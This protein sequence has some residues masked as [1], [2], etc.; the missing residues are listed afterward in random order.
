MEINSGDLDFFVK[1]FPILSRYPNKSK[2]YQ[3]PKLQTK[4]EH[5]KNEAFFPLCF[6]RVD[7][8]L[9]QALLPLLTPKY[10]YIFVKSWVLFF[11]ALRRS[12]SAQF[13][14]FSLK[15]ESR[16]IERPT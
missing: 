12:A 15:S 11:G 8:A 3:F 10:M 6:G 14:Q 2:K 4:N 7:L 9:A 16:T 1:L 5:N 13:A